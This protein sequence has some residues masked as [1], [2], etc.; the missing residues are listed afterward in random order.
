[1]LKFR[2][3]SVQYHAFKLFSIAAYKTPHWLRNGFAA[4]VGEGYYWLAR[5]HSRKADENIRRVLGEPTVNRRVRHIARRSFRNYIKYMTELLRNPHMKLEE[6]E[7]A[8]VT[9]SWHD[10]ENAVATKGLMTVTV[11][12]GNWD[13]AG[14]LV[15]VRGYRTTSVAND[16]N[17][18]DLNE[19]IQGTRRH[20]GISIYSATEKETVRKLYTALERREIVALV[21]NSPLH[22]SEG[23][24]VDF[25]G[26]PARFPKGPAAIAL[27]K[28]VAVL[29]GFVARQPGNNTYYALWSKPLECEPTGDRNRDIQ[30]LTQLIANEV[31]KLVRR[32]PDQWYMF[33]QLWLTPQ[34]A[35]EYYEQQTLL[36]NSNGHRKT[37]VKH[38]KNGVTRI[39]AE[40]VVSV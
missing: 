32:H 37:L 29:V 9:G 11:H 33:R 36:K 20:R 21:L 27:K 6:I 1:M 39:P 18:P 28:G 15:G 26:A 30:C 24:I 31:E 12:F 23:V 5:E 13:I 14:G 19:L 38:S 34:E 3:H 40:S 10:L 22:S 17:P 4:V 25:F 16:F 2:N 7:Q 35:T 8:V